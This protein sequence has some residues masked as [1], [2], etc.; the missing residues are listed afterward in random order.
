MDRGAWWATA[1]GVA[2]S[3]DTTEQHSLSRNQRQRP[4]FIIQWS[5][6]GSSAGTS[7]VAQRL[8]LCT[9]SVGGVDSIPGWGM[10]I[11]HAMWFTKK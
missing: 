5:H 11:P 9:S 4:A 3:Q 7:L 6:Y 8:R 1:Q 10:K 2:W